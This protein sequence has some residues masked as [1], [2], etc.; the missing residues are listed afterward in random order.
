MAP[1]EFA[2]FDLDKIVKDAERRKQEAEKEKKVVPAAESPAQTVVSDY[3]NIVFENPVYHHPVLI[4][5][6]LLEYDKSLE[7]LRKAG[8][9]RHARPKEVF[10]LMI[11]NIE[12]MLS[13]EYKIVHDN[14][15]LN[16]REWLSLAW[17]RQGDILTAYLDP[18]GVFSRGYN[19]DKI[20]FKFTKEAKFNIAGKK[21][22]EK[23]IDLSEFDDDFVLWHYGRKFKD[24]PEKMRVGRE[25]SR[26]MLPYEDGIWPVVRSA[27]GIGKYRMEWDVDST[28]RGVRELKGGSQ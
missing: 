19:F 25:R 9:E 16:A 20:N 3:R 13:D 28:S 17:E 12:G 15:F 2:G 8:F 5:K 21:S 24:L 18:E 14:M 1:D 23:F 11:D 4:R 22:E 26:I 27:C 7:R 10:G 6:E